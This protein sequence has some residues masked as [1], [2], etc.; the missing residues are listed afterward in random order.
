[1]KTHNLMLKATD[2]V[3]KGLI[4]T[5]Y[6]DAEWQRYVAVLREYYPNTY[7]GRL[8]IRLQ[9]R[10][11]FQLREYSDGFKSHP[12]DLVRWDS[13]AVKLI[14]NANTALAG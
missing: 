2:Q 1:M 9:S 13:I 12:W 7:T 10:L 4:N 14:D 8:E 3:Y 6:L 5:P 11:P